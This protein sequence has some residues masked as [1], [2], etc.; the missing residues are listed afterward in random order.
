LKPAF[1]LLELLVV[2]AVIAVLVAIAIPTAT[3]INRYAARVK[4]ISNLRQIGVAARLFAND[5]NMRLPAK[6]AAPADLLEPA[7]DCWP[8]LF[9]AYL[10]PSDPR[11]FL[12]PLDRTTAKLPLEEV[13]SNAKNNTGF[14]YNGFDDLFGNGARAPLVS[15]AAIERPGETLLMSQKAP[16]VT[17]FYVDLL[18]NPV[19]VLTSL[20]NPKVFDG[21]AH[22]LYVDGSVRYLKESEYSNK[23]W[24]TDKTLDL[25]GILP[26]LFN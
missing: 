13:L 18:G 26:P 16:G 20:L 24:L 14:I 4:S 7:P 1:T 8:K 5:H 6:A 12:D 19:N 22:Y 2:M 25:S 9:C 17:E 15:L 21:G 11:V 3:G 23:L 10:T